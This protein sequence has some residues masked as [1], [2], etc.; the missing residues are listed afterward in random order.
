[1]ERR[2]HFVSAA[3]AL[4]SVAALGVLACTDLTPPRLLISGGGPAVED[5]PI[6][7]LEGGYVS[8]DACRACHP[9]KYATWYAS[10]HRTMTQVVEPDTV[11]A[12]F[13]DVE[14][15]LYGERFVLERRGDEFWAEMDDPDFKGRGTAPRVWKQLV[16]STGSHH[17]Q[18]F[19]VPT[20]KSR[21]LSLFP[22]CY[23]IDEGRW[24]PM[25]SAF[26]Q[27]PDV[28]MEGGKGRWNVICQQC[29]TTKG[30]MRV[31]GDEMDTHAVEFGIACEA[32]H[33]PGAEHVSANQDPKRRYDLHFGDESD[34]TIVDPMDLSPRLASMACGQCHGITRLRKGEDL[35]AWT[36]EGYAYQPGE[37]LMSRRF[38]VRKSDGHFWKDGMVR[39]SGREYNSLV[40]N[41][42]YKH[43]DEERMMTCFS[44]HQLHQDPD[45]SRSLDVWRNQQLKPDM[46]GDL[47]CTQCHTEYSDTDR[48]AEHT[49]HE[50]ATAGSSC[51]NCHMPYTT[52]GLLKA[53]RTH[54]VNS[55]DTAVSQTTGRPNACNLCHLDQT[56]GW[57]ADWLEE[58]YEVPHP[59]LTADEET[60]AASIL[61]LLK[62]DAGQ[63]A[64]MA[65]ALGWEPALEVS[66]SAWT[67]PY[68]AQLLE[69]PYDPVRFR[70]ARSLRG[71]KDFGDLDYDFAGP[72]DQQVAAHAR[73]REIW[74]A[75]IREDEPPN[76]EAL[77][78]DASGRLRQ[79]TFDRLLEQRDDTPLVLEE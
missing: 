70:A 46:N 14:L 32:C 6:E 61:W 35:Q 8:S 64:L 60:I 55:P 62:G 69:D 42:C 78:L 10:Y 49:R 25:D 9:H 1:M 56:L 43:G 77:L 57:T 75:I 23:R 44:C 11:V 21:K 73:A 24:M 28:R 58:W 37:D 22:F 2:R 79:E 29:H 15:E 74:N 13:D 17:F 34:P 72:L 30:K 16:M 31:S 20:G 65:W 19:W 67:A 52:W 26:I 27:P 53:I 50:P 38:L 54:Q 71:L 76:H 39:V 18:V 45:D 33:G 7:V 5:R 12:D 47:A 59:E 3:A 40:S 68:L 48:V 51:L 4:A 41:P 63:R 36:Q 66:G